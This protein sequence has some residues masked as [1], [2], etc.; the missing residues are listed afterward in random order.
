MKKYEHDPPTQIEILKTKIKI[1]K[2]WASEPN[3]N[4]IIDKIQTPTIQNEY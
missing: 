1:L 3:W 4:I 2:V